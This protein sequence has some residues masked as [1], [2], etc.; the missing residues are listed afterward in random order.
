MLEV[1]GPNHTV[2]TV[3]MRPRTACEGFAVSVGNCENKDC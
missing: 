1:F 3:G 2:A